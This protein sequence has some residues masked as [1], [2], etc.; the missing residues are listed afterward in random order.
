M[1]V[2]RADGTKVGNPLTFNGDSFHYDQ[3]PDAPASDDPTA[4]ITTRKAGSASP[5]GRSTA[6][7]KR[8]VKH[9]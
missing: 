3:Y 4:T 8:S 2:T 9:S 7:A 1:Q 5:T 6:P